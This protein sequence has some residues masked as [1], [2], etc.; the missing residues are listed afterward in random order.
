MTVIPFLFNFRF[1]NYLS[2]SCNKIYVQNIV[3]LLEFRLSL[4]RGPCQFCPEASTTQA[5][6]HMSP[7]TKGHL[8]LS[9]FKNK[10]IQRNQSVFSARFEFQLVTKLFKIVIEV[11]LLCDGFAL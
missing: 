1:V 6:I 9:S 7:Q 10:K 3:Y 11:S 2:L 8:E 5:E 4:F